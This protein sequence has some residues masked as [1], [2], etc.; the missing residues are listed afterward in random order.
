[1]G[2]MIRSLTGNWKYWIYFDLDMKL[3]NTDEWYEMLGQFESTGA[4][5][6]CL[7][8]DMGG[9]NQGRVVAFFQKS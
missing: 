7:T 9:S 3:T 4:I 8:C 1:M 2:F 6:K 5:I